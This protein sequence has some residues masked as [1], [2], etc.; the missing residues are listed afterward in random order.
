MEIA[1]LEYR[2]FQR[3]EEILEQPLKRIQ[4]HLPRPSHNNLDTNT[5]RYCG[6]SLVELCF[7]RLING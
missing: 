4:R 6:F 3:G 5:R 7:A 1:Y 2:R